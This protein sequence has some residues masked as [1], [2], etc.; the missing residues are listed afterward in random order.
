L[1][2]MQT[3]EYRHQTSDDRH[4]S[5]EYRRAYARRHV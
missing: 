1:L 4:P 5:S 3:G 2:V